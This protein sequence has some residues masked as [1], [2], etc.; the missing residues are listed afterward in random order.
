MKELVKSGVAAQHALTAAFFFLPLFKPVMF[1]SLL[2]AIVLFLASDRFSEAWRQA[3][4]QSWLLPALILSILPG[5]SLLLHDD[6]TQTELNLS[7]YWLAAFLVYLASSRMRIVPWLWA[8]VAGIFIVFC[9]VQIRFPGQVELATGLAAL[10]N[11]ILYSQL[12]AIAVVLL[13][14][15]YKHETR[16]ILRL[17]CVAGMAVFFFGLV[18]GDGRSGLLSLL[19]LFPLVAGNMVSKKNRRLVLVVCLAGLLATAM[20]PRVQK[21]INAGINDLK[22]MQQ[23]RKDTSLGYRLDMWQT[24]ADVVRAHPVFGAGQAGFE[25]AWHARHP[26][27]QAQS[28]IEP[29]NAFLFFASAFG[30]IG[31][32][33]L[34]W[35]YAAMLWTGWCHRHTMEGGVVF[36]FAVVCIVGSVTNTMFMGAVS[37]TW[38]MLFIGLQGSLQHPAVRRVALQSAAESEQRQRQPA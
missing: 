28:F 30:L 7:Y 15:L 1:L 2:A 23:D 26:K 13:S 31:L 24:A 5:L 25:K 20:A 38:V 10:G 14:I 6:P 35:L 37:H 12:L 33:A 18:S 29:H 3:T 4:L 8:F 27:G 16:R 21:R 22:L 9:Y 32:A 36:A 17:I 19:L 11:Y 34:V